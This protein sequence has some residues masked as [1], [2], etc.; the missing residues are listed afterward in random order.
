MIRPSLRAV[1]MFGA[2]LSAMACEARRPATRVPIAT[3]STPTIPTRADPPSR[4]RSSASAV[5][6]PS[7]DAAK[8]AALAAAVAAGVRPSPF[9]RGDTIGDPQPGRRRMPWTTVLYKGVD[10]KREPYLV[11]TSVTYWAKLPAAT[12]HADGKVTIAWRTRTNA[13]RGIVYLGLR[14]E[15]DPIAAPRFREFATEDLRRPA[16]EHRVTHSLG[17][18]L[19]RRYDVSG[20]LERGYG[21]L[22][23]QVEQFIP[24]VGTTVLYDGRTAFRREGE[25]LVQQPTIVL[26]PHV[27]QVTPESFIVSFE[28]DVPT[29]AAVAVADRVPKVSTD[30]GR[31]HEILVEGLAPRTRYA[32]QVAVSDGVE[33]SVA[34][35]REVTTRAR[36]GTVK[37]AIMSDSRAGIGGGLHAYDG[38][39]AGALRPLVTSSLRRGAQAIFFVG[40][41]VN[42]YVT[43]PQDFDHQLRTWLKVVEGVGGTIPIYTGMGNHEAVLDQWSDGKALGRTGAMSTEARFAALM[44]NPGGAP[45]PERDEAPP[46]D[47]TVYS[48]DL[49]RVHFVML[50]TNYWPSSHP[51]HER[52]Q[53]AGNR[54]GYLMDGQL[55]WLDRD[56]AAARERGAEHIVVMGHE[57]AFPVAGH[58][59]D[60]MWWNGEH[61][62]V[63][64]MRERF[65]KLMA[66]HG[67]LAYVAGDEHN[68]SRALIGPETVAGAQ[69]SIHSIVTGGCGAPYYA[70]DTPEAYRDRVRAF[71]PQQH[72]TMW[73]FAPGKPPRLQ[74][75]GLT[76]EV[77][78][79]VELTVAEAP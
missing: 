36:E 20:A 7:P 26:G 22:V 72:Y 29:A 58:A 74:A 79:D 21:E 25:A 28:T 53:G 62:D 49:G 27:H 50:N 24:E 11:D 65:W 14:V 18:T 52:Y 56:L 66:S 43:H 17:R 47:E 78:D 16:R 12:L 19:D 69:T 68:Y 5:V 61:A 76:G 51:G 70:Q 31:R 75:I 59:K 33:A 2:L 42:G 4:E 6:L 46:Y 13:P 15:A 32:Y 55:A 71:D 60:A 10:D 3:E 67:V 48:V 8:R 23:W 73:T 30:K 44:V 38:T 9:G 77:L 35:P 63:N 40:D 34:P 39:N 37:V 64:A 54:E 41:L 1:A 45:P 57:P